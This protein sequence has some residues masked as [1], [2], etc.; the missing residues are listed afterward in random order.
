MKKILIVDDSQSFLDLAEMML[1]EKYELEFATSAIEAI[2]MA[3]SYVYDAAI[4]DVALPDY[5][6]YY[7]GEQLKK[8][9]PNIRLAFLT[10]YDGDVTRENACI[11]NAKFWYKPNIIID[12]T[13]FLEHVRDLVEYV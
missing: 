12:K 7:L 13:I 9:H 1:S 3:K 5:T 2:N 10:N 8:L 11:L 6:G 4:L